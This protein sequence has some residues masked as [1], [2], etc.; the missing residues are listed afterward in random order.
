MVHK[1]QIPTLFVDRRQNGRQK[2][3]HKIQE[4]YASRNA[5]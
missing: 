4:L 1:I 3:L 2:S 5:E